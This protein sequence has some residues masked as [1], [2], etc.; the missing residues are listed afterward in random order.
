MHFHIKRQAL[1]IASCFLPFIV[2]A[3]TTAPI[4]Q[5]DNI[6]VT[7]SRQAQLQKDV[8]GDISVISSIE[9]EKAGQNSLVDLLGK[10][11]GVQVYSSGGPQGPAG[12]SLRGTEARHT[13]VLVDG[14]RIN[15]SSIGGISWQ[16]LDPATI[17]QVE[18]IRGAASGLYG[19]DAI[20]GVINIITKKAGEDRP[21]AAWGNV[22]VGSYDTFKS[23]IGFSGAAAGFDYSLS[24]SMAE[25]GGFNASNLD[26][27]PFTYHPDTDGYSQHTLSASLGYRWRPGQHLGV[28]A[29][30]GYMNGD[31]DAGTY[32][33]PAF[34]ITRQQAY[35]LTSTNEITDYWESTLRFGL[36]KGA[37]DSRT[38]GNASTSSLLQR[39]YLWQNSFKINDNHQVSS[40]FE[41][42][43]ERPSSDAHYTVSTRN[44][45]A[46]GAIYI[47]TFGPAHIQAN[48]RN[49]NVSG[50]GNRATGGLA[51]D[52]DL[53]DEWQVGMS[54]NTGFKAPTFTDMY[55]PYQWGFSGNPNLKPERS[56]NVEA[57]LKYNTADTQIGL[58]IYQ[59]KIKDLIDPYVCLNGDFNNCTTQNVAS[60]TIRGATITAVYQYE[61]TTFRAS[62]DF[63]NA[64][65]NTTGNQLARRARQVYNVGI[66]H[67]IGLLSL[68]AEY[69]FTGKRYSNADN[70]QETRMGGYSLMNLTA[71]Y[72]FTK[73]VGVQVR[74]NNVLDKKYS[75]NYGYNMPRSNVFVNLAWR[76]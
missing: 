1:A 74:W 66:D 30:N 38:G 20:G 25:S 4:S 23:S 37:S 53:S 56:R 52:Y 2:T 65:D 73:N 72:D 63:M 58:V 69:Q 12:V 34:S 59:N 61:N 71:G 3:Q 67:R 19:S 39:S 49:D 32:S 62:A 40:I 13:L 7:P 70:S 55:A 14:L 18:I 8:V 45:N 54:G 26:S 46:V 5:L 47:G 57:R 60:A 6:V 51:L 44:T 36:T 17:E 75:S 9:L 16:A 43:E 15:N 28:T 21:F 33:H 41:R 29:Y 11:P 42:Q 24:S 35:T 48:L 50:Y 10:Q 22:G 64:K 27:G 76:M 31:F 68:G